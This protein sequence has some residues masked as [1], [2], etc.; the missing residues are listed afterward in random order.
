M[1]TTE[2][3]I[4]KKELGGD[5]GAGISGALLG[6][7]MSPLFSRQAGVSLTQQVG[8]SLYDNRDKISGPIFSRLSKEDERMFEGLVIKLNKQKVGDAKLAHKGVPYV[9]IL[10][11]LLKRMGPW[12]SDRYRSIAIG[13]PKSATKK[14]K[15]AAKDGSYVETDLADSGENLD[16]QVQFLVES[17]E[18]VI[19]FGGDKVNQDPPDFEQGIEVVLQNLRIRN[20]VDADSAAAKI[21]RWWH[22]PMNKDEVALVIAKGKQLLEAVSSDTPP[23]VIMTSN[24]IKWIVNN[25]L[26]PGETDTVKFKWPFTSAHH[27]APPIRRSRR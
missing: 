20:I 13:I 3:R 9:D 27:A 17:I 19:R 25:W 21:S 26:T 6:A 4:S 23:Q 11:L 22:E 1:A 2:D 10:N 12:A 14:K 15:E 16:P 7:L 24:P 8:K 5:I 18:D